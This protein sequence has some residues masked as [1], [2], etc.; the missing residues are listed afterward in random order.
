MTII[1]KEKEF[2]IPDNWHFQGKK[3]LRKAG[4][5]YPYQQWQIDE[6]LKCKYD[7]EYFSTK[8]VKI[9]HDSEEVYFSP[10][11]YQREM[12]KRMEHNRFNI[13]MIPRQS[14]KTTTTEVFILHR[15]IFNENEIVGI[16]ANKEKTA[17][18]ILDEIEDMQKKL[19]F[20][21]QQ[22]AITFAKSELELENGSKI[23][24]EATSKYSLSGNA[25][26][27]VYFDEAA[28][29]H[30][31]IME[32]F[33]NAISPTISSSK[34]SRMIISSTP[35]GYNCFV[36][37]WFDAVN[38]ISEY[39][40]FTIK[41]YEVPGRDE[42]F[43]E[44]E[45]K[46][47]GQLYWDQEFECLVTASDITLID[48]AKLSEIQHK[49]PIAEF[50]DSNLKIYETPN[51]EHMYVMTVDVGE[52]KGEGDYSTFTIFDSSTMPYIPIITY[53]NN[54]IAYE[55]FPVI[56]S[57]IAKLFTNENLVIVVENNSIG[58]VVVKKLNWELE[59]DA[60]IFSEKGILG[61]HTT[62][63]TKKIGCK[64]FKDL[65]EYDKLKIVD[66]NS[67]NEAFHFIKK[68]DSF[69]A[70]EGYTDDLIMNYVLFSYI[71]TLPFFADFIEGTQIKK[72]NKFKEDIDKIIEE[73]PFFGIVNARG[74]EMEDDSWE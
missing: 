68:G 55:L 51:K 8:Y 2:K 17:L 4:I 40:P 3:G 7:I 58:D 36:R 37:L 44:R 63:K 31:N 1:P 41:W 12:L 59:T 72:E 5:S 60:T 19:P 38:K 67:I 43:K 11:D 28:L 57:E 45:I 34:R 30:S 42:N 47:H 35:K 50:Y 18:K 56:I 62:K 54:K 16:V 10:Y 22:G 32:D 53:R 61:L 9:I 39:I 24:A 69:K 14:G 23:I 20:F 48:G 73:V 71:T 46:K 27:L 13:F 66:Y 6:I 65:F 52:G 25:L 21:L 70:D 49:N 74:I 29:V 64:T 26:S 15:I 33:I